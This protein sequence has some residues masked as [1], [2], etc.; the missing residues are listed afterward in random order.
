MKKMNRTYV[1]GICCLIIAAA[2][3]WGA[4]KVSTTLVSNEPGP[5]LFPCLSAIGIAVFSILSMIFDG[6]KE[7]GKP[8]LDKSGYRRLVLIIAECLVFVLSMQL[9]G[10]WITAM[11]G[12]YVFIW[13]LKERKINKIFALVFSIILASICY[14]GFTRGFHIPL[15]KG[16]IFTT[17]GIN[18]P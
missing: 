10:F 17:L 2:I 11:A 8:Y 3:F 1:M 13:T 14:F 16:V 7:A 4:S 12:L 9:I 15:P 6:P 5:R 18:M